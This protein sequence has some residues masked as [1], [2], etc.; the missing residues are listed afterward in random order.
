MSD[1]KI[2]RSH[3]NQCGGKTKHY[4]VAVRK[5]QGCET[6]EEDFTI[7]WGARYSLLEC[8]GC[9]E[10]SVR[11]TSWCSEDPPDYENV[12]YFPTRVSRREPP[13]FGEISQET[14]EL[15]REIYGALHGD[16][17]R[18]ALMGARTVID[19]LLFRQVGDSGTFGQRLDRLEKKGFLSKIDR[20][21]LEAALDAGH[22]AAHRA[23]NPDPDN[24]N[25][26]MD[27]VE[28]VLQAENLRKRADKLSQATPPR[29]A[30]GAP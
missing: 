29:G 16:Q 28:N 3:C 25:L 19:G 4:V 27:I 18:L 20:Q 12:E 30:P 5:Q 6:I 9:E 24:L 15:M 2:A 1:E 13:W 7:H 8:C 21:T 22:A 26:V 17:R 14:S 10:I 23:Y 11:R